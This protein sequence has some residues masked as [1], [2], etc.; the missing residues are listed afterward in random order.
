MD[1]TD[2]ERKI[3]Q[4]LCDK[5]AQRFR[6]NEKTDVEEIKDIISS[7][8]KAYM[9]FSKIGVGVQELADPSPKRT[10]EIGI[11]IHAAWMHECINHSKLSESNKYLF[12]EY[13]HVEKTRQQL[14]NKVF[15]TLMSEIKKDQKK[16]AVKAMPATTKE[17]KK[18][19]RVERDVVGPY[20]YE[21]RVLRGLDYIL[22][23]SSEDTVGK[24]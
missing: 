6:V 7:A 12:D 14:Y 24:R 20:A 4:E 22:Y 23:K 11:Y 8:M 9:H 16:Y 13:G 17:E 3:G 1:M 18:A 5:V 19:L 21:E 10:R 2:E 15:A